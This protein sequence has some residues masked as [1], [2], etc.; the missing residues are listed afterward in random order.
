MMESIQDSMI[1]YDG[2]EDEKTS[3]V[4]VEIQKLEKILLTQL[5]L[6]INSNVSYAAFSTCEQENQSDFHQSN[7]LFSLQRELDEAV[8]L[9][10]EEPLVSQRIQEFEHLEL[11]NTVQSDHRPPTFTVNT[12]KPKTTT[13][14]R[15][16]T[17]P[18]RSQDLQESLLTQTQRIKSM[19]ENLEHQLNQTSDTKT[20]TLKTNSEGIISSIATLRNLEDSLQRP[21]QFSGEATHQKPAMPVLPPIHERKSQIPV[22]TPSASMLS[23]KDLENHNRMQ[24]NVDNQ[25]RM[26][27]IRHQLWGN[28]RVDEESMSMISISAQVSEETN[29]CLPQSL[30]SHVSEEESSS[31]R[32]DPYAT[33]SSPSCYAPYSINSCNLDL[34][35]IDLTHTNIPEQQQPSASAASST[36]EKAYR[37]SYQYTPS[38]SESQDQC[39]QV[40]PL[41]RLLTSMKRVEHY[42]NV[43]RRQNTNPQ[44]PKFREV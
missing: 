39:C 31:S 10:P 23:S 37:A 14:F 1:S 30:S 2:E 17:P 29:G 22:V 12:T 20:T 24:D 25:N 32:K 28:Q 3:E 36:Y 6:E 4:L 33:I 18:E 13:T 44:P 35:R 41:S 27:Q 11:S 16:A 42:V 5:D 38:C 19:L 7:S 9:E 26:H 8:Y 43:C 21:Q 34:S 40:L 15:K